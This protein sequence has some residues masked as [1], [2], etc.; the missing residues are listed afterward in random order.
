MDNNYRT[1]SVSDL[2]SVVA[3]YKTKLTEVNDNLVAL[4]TELLS[5]DTVMQP[6]LDLDDEYDLQTVLLNMS[7][8]HPEKEVRDKCSELDTVLSQFCTEQSMRKDVFNVFSK[9]YLNQYQ[10]EKE[11]LNS[12]QVRLVEKSMK[13]YKIMG[14]DLEDDKYNRL[15]EYKKELIELS[16]TYDLNLTNYKKEFEFTAEQLTGCTEKW[17][18]SR[19][20]ENGNYKVTLKYPDYFGVMEYCKNRDTRKTL[21]LAYGQRCMKENTEIAEK[22][23]KIRHEM[24]LLLG[25]QNFSDY[26]LQN[27]MA[28]TTDT[29]YSFLENLVEK[30]AEL[31]NKDL[32]ALK[33]LA[34]EDGVDELKSFDT[35]YYSRIYQESQTQL[36]KDELRKY[37]PLDKVKTGLFN[38]YEQL[39]GFKFVDVSDKFRSTRWHDEVE[40]FEVRNSSDNSLAG[41]FMLDLFPREGKY[42]HAA[43]FP[44]IRRS[45]RNMPVCAMA[46]NF[47]KDQNL[48]FDEVETFFHEF[49]HV[50]HSMCAQSNLSPL[51]SSG[52]ERD[53]VEAPSQMFEEW[54]YRKS[55]LKLMADDIPDDVIVKLNKQRKILQGMYVRRQITLGLFDMSMHGEHYNESSAKV[56]NT[57]A[58]ELYKISP[59][60]ETSFVAHFGHIMHGYEAGYYGYMWSRVYATD[61]FESKFKDHELDPVLGKELRDKILS[62]GYLRDSMESL[63]DFLGRKP[64]DD[65][66][67]SSLFDE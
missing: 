60:P 3:N 13:D 52:C 6:T 5:W 10:S 14:M 42:G 44:L 4:D 54:C 35:A 31:L 64:T 30:S 15:K 12:Q 47:S 58:S 67:I 22:V 62:H 59:L 53:F 66:F 45:S 34:K 21:A 1:I 24:A 9:Y 28:K 55:S 11:N 38:I 23:F 43:V 49:G 7:S 63:E 65:A 40:S 8:F 56:Y 48:E 17:L 57:L 46:C 19:K 51:S 25:F 18:E 50:M 33:S 61:M 26:R 41:Y 36:N 16:N 20:Q 37:F 32:E 29:V 2:E 27:R 39:L